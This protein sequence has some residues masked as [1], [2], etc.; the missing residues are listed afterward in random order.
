VVQRPVYL[1]DPS[2]P[3]V[4][5]IKVKESHRNR[6]GVWKPPSL[7]VLAGL[8]PVEWEVSIVDENLGVPD[9]AALPPYFLFFRFILLTY[10]RSSR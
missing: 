2:N 6:Y 7:M 4:S 9:Y 1:I 10:P 3:L 5:I 8:T